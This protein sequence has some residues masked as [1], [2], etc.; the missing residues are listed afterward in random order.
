MHVR[1][2]WVHAARAGCLLS[3][4]ARRADA[5]VTYRNLDDPPVLVQTSYSGAPVV[6]PCSARA[7]GCQSSNA[8]TRYGWLMGTQ[9]TLGDSHEVTVNAEFWR[10][11]LDSTTTVTVVFTQGEAGLDPAISLYGGLLPDAAHDDTAFDPTNPIDSAGC[12]AA[13]PKD[14]HEL[15]YVYVAHDG[16]R[17]TKD[18]SVTGGLSA[19]MPVSPYIGQFDAFASWSMANLDGAWGRIQYIASVSATPFTGRDGGM[20]FDGN[21]ATAPGTGESMTVTLPA[22]DYTIA[23]GGEACATIVTACLNP[24]LFGTVTLTREAADA[25]S[26]SDAGQDEG[27]ATSFDG[28]AQGTGGDRPNNGT[29][30][31]TTPPTDEKKVGGCNLRGVRKPPVSAVTALAWL[32]VALAARRRAR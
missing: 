26:S 30:G 13:S 32:L 2:E 25:A 20:H 5:H 15:P 23:A 17:D 18:C 27:G 12:A 24:R 6:D 16:Y 22:G 7:I 4:V 29:G 19:C 9:P 10:F 21:H 28:G 11:H 1:K 14:A 31:D 8:F 3:V